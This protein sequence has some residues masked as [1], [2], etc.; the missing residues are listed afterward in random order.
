M[1]VYCGNIAFPLC[2]TRES[3]VNFPTRPPPAKKEH[4]ELHSTHTLPGYL[5]FHALGK[6]EKGCQLEA[7]SDSVVK[8]EA[9]VWRQRLPELGG[10]FPSVLNQ[11]E[12]KEVR[13]PK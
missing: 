12:Q 10:S 6:L 1:C 5:R 2:V 7:D 11:P 4:F 8:R 13:Y 9:R 3:T